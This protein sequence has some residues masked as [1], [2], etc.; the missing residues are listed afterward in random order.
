MASKLNFFIWKVNS[1][2]PPVKYFGRDILTLSRHKFISKYRILQILFVF[3]TLK[4]FDQLEY[5]GLPPIEAFHNELDNTECSE[6]DY[7]FTTKFYDELQLRNFGDY[8]LL[9]NCLGNGYLLYYDIFIYCIC[10]Y[11]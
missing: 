1:Q 6:E 9:Y 11:I 2:K 10:F 7:T 8:T 3:P 4:H 5:Q